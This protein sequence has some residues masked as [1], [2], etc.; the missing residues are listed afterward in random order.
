MSEEERKKAEEI[1]VKIYAMGA[2][3]VAKAVREIEESAKKTDKYAM[4]PIAALTALI[5]GSAIYYAW[6]GSLL[7]SYG[8]FFLGGMLV[9][10]LI[11]LITSYLF[12]KSAA[13]IW[14]DTENHFK[15]EFEEA[16]IE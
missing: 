6:E 2:Y 10:L 8:F 7:V 16:E 15:K 5:L 13:K 12:H 4:I 3:D 1:A 14:R 11:S 9:G